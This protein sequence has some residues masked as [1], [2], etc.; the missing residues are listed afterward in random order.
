[1]AA[2]LRELLSSRNGVREE[3]RRVLLQAVMVNPDSQ[4]NLSK[5]ARL[6]TATVSDAVRALEEQGL[7]RSE[8]VGRG[9]IVRMAET[10]GAVVGIE[11]GRHGAAVVARRVDQDY[12]DAAS[13]V[14]QVSLGRGDRLW[15]PGVVQAVREVVDEIGQEDVVAVGLGVPWMIDPRTGTLVPPLLPP[16]ED[17]EDPAKVLAEGLRE[18]LRDRLVAPRVVLDNDSNLMAY[19]ESI[20]G[21]PGAET[22]IAIK[23]STGIGA[24]IVVG[25]NIFRG[26]RGVAGEFGHFSV[27][28]DG[29]FCVCG[30]RGCL[31]TLVGVDVLVEQAKAALGRSGAP[32]NF[33]GLVTAAAEGSVACQRVLWEAGFT[34]GLSI[35]NLCNILNPDVVVLGG[36]YGRTGAA[37]FTLEACREGI[38]HTGMRAAVSETD[39]FQVMASTLDYPA[40]HGALAMALQG[41]TFLG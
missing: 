26:R 38:H 20:Y 28:S 24:G 23:A 41:T 18:D 15:L 10:A 21:S 4:A 35:G 3:N 29:R 36:A 37:P 22:L 19:A 34:L 6:S 14:L 40:A 16:W 27:Q 31:E 5:R 30:G 1:M 33:E 32:V 9:A 2:H 8:K 12:Q 7:V 39:G 11:L 25:G 17:G 13:R